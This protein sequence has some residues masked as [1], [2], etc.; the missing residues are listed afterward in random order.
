MVV[1]DEKK[2]QKKGKK[3]G[4]GGNFKKFLTNSKWPHISF[5]SVNLGDISQS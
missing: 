2:G 5:L 1:Q 4:K 3:G